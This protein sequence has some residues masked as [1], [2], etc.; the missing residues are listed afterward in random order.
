MCQKT[1]DL[2]GKIFP[3]VNNSAIYFTHMTELLLQK[4][5]KNN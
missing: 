3:V 1:G 4:Y 2:I 5:N